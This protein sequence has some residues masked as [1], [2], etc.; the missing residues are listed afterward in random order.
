MESMTALDTRSAREVAAA[1]FAAEDAGDWPRLISM[2]DPESMEAFKREQLAIARMCDAPSRL[3]AEE[4]G[5][6]GE[7]AEQFRRAHQAP[8]SLLRHVYKVRSIS[9]FEAVPAVVAVERFLRV[10]HR[11][12]IRDGRPTDRVGTRRIIG[13]TMEG[14][15]L[16]HIVFR[17][18]FSVAPDRDDPASTTAEIEARDWVDVLTL[19]RTPT[20]WRATL[21][22]GLVGS[23]GG[24]FSIGFDP[25][26]GE[27]V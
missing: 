4:L 26:A 14:E 1:V 22:G 25:D 11:P 8:G 16:A 13:E 17:E 19:R 21:N 12:L 27:D 9:E 10:R 18:V 7:A 5:M 6:A 15:R 3:S 23:S 24:G 2:L 20:G